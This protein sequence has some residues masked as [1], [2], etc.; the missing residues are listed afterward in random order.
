MIEIMDT[1]L[2]DGEQTSGVSFSAREKLNIARF[3]LQEL[4]VDRIEIASARVSDGEMDGAREIADWANAYGYLDRVEVLGFVDGGTS[5]NWIMKSGCRAINLLSKGS[6]KH[7]TE[8]LGKKP[9]EHWDDIRR[10]IDRANSLGIGVNLYLEDWSNGMIHS[11]EYVHG[12]IEILQD[13]PIKRFLLPD[14][15]GVLNPWNTEEYCTDMLRRFP[16]MRFDFHSHNDYDL[17]VAN[18][19]A[20]VRSGIHGI[21]TTINGLG[22]RAGNAPLSSVL[23]VLRDQLQVECR[24]KENPINRI[25]RM[26]ESC[27]G[28]HIPSNKPI[29]GEHVFTQCAGIHADGDSKNDLYYND[30]LPERFGR[31]REYALGKLSGKANIRKNLEALSIHLDDESMRLVTNRI[32][33]LGDKKEI[34]TTEDLPY[35]IA[36]VLKQDKEEEKVRILNY[37]LSLTQG[38]K[39]VATL[40]ICINGHE[41][42]ETSTGDGQYNA[43]VRALKKIYKNQLNREFPRLVNYSVT[44]PPGGR[45]DAFV[46][47]VIVWE[48]MGKSF[49]TRGFDADQT[50]SAIKATAKMLNKI[51]ELALSL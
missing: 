47:T 11:P 19:A 38:L 5:L 3:L 23:A 7:C 2:R 25:S 4:G 30:L 21:H 28:V 48:Y 50:E 45:T 24:V 20:A 37:S 12:M 9:G 1:T 34:V 35:I 15:L 10:E 36:D 42:Q 8:Q 17:A 26:V 13:C 33:E 14:T 49:R 22:E 44:I 27:S 32:I 16:S 40:K 39:P 18:V 41:Y 29:I 31:T 43:F 6:L 51:E 46:Q